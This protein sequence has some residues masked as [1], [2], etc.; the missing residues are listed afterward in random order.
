M[1]RRRIGR[2]ADGLRQCIRTSGEREECDVARVTIHDHDLRERALVAVYTGHRERRLPPVCIRCGEPATSWFRKEFAGPP[3]WTL[4]LLPLALAL[5][6]LSTK[7]TLDLPVCDRHADPWRDRHRFRELFVNVGSGG[8]YAIFGTSLLVGLLMSPLVQMTP[9]SVVIKV[10]PALVLL[11]WL[12]AALGLMVA[13]VVFVFLSIRPIW[14]SAKSITLTGVS[15]RFVEAI[16]RQRRGEK[17]V[18]VDEDP[19]LPELPP[20]DRIRG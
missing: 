12:V 6:A 5:T 8:F 15:S 1:K 4:L 3:L 11:S 10:L 7:W 16:V 2:F 19:H 14:I 18:E 9:D 17:P 13:R 20:D